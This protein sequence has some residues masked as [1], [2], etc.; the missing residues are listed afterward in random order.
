MVINSI[1]LAGTLGMGMLG[2]VKYREERRKKAFPW[3]VAAKRLT[4][5]KK[6]VLFVGQHGFRA[7]EFM[8]E[9]I[10]P[11]VSQTRRQQLTEITAAQEMLEVSEAEKEAKRT[12]MLA[13]CS[14]F[15][16]AS[17]SLFYAPLYVPVAPIIAYLFRDIFRDA[18]QALVEERRVSIDMLTAIEVLGAVLSG[19]IVMATFG[20]WYQKLMRLLLSKTENHSRKSLVNL[21]GQQPRFVWILVDSADGAGKKE[22]EI[23]FEQLKSGD[24]VVVM[25]GQTIPIDG[26]IS[27]GM[28]SI[29]Q[30][31]LT[32]EA[33]P[34]QKGVEESVFAG[35]VVLS[36]QIVVRAEQ[37]GEH[38]VVAQ[39]GEILN[40]TADF[41]TK[42]RSRAE[43]LQD[44]L[45]PAL[46]A[47]A[48]LSFPWIG[49]SGALA[50][51][52]YS[53]GFKMIIFGPMSMVN[54][55][56]IC[57]QKR[58]LIKDGRS[59]E[60][61]SEIDTVVFDKTGTLTIEQPT[62]SRITSLNALSEE[63]LLIHAAAAEYKQ[64]HPIAKAILSAAAERGLDVP[65]IDDAHYEI[66]YGVKVR[67]H[68]HGKAPKTIRVGSERF[69]ALEGITIPASIYAQQAACHALGVSTVMV[70]IDEQLSGTIELR[71][72]IRPEAKE[73]VRCLQAAGKT[74]TIISG[75]HEMPTRQLAEELGI[76]KYFANT[77][78]E[79]KA[80]LVAQLQQ[81]GKSVCF[82]GDGINDA[83]ALKKANVSISLRG[84]TTVATDSAQIVLMDEN[85][86]QLTE[87][88]EIAQEFKTNTDRTY[89]STIIPNTVGIAAT[90]FLHWGYAAAVLLN[91]ALWIPQLAYVMHPLYK[92]KADNRL[93]QRNN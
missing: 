85:L 52:W 21:F 90:F 89:L 69:M 58:I 22:V 30:R 15:L 44:Q 38:T 49:L 83:I 28:A 3:T 65:M 81:E 33:Q 56:H 47:L 18:S 91:A 55:L 80:E 84:A 23:P 75:D 45:A 86:T 77:L 4:K 20:I 82:V 63:E 29:D 70:A 8:G 61:L 72:T 31:M 68:A 9:L 60:L 42:I 88:F 12:F 26:T 62:V 13:S 51:L 46:L 11:Y 79:N 78:P 19:F 43:T 53:P 2:A 92:H 34:A 37:A 25:A 71:P 54:F 10:A 39:I 14:V 36:G 5:K 35:T 59:L 40:H 76:E 87:V 67:L 32:G 50:I 24:L 66:G 7:R 74:V 73:V 41:D 17:G 57:S 64:T 16:A 1:V 6:K 93:P 48:G 27:R